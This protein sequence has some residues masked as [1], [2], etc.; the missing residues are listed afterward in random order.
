M[1]RWTRACGA[2]ARRALAIEIRAPASAPVMAMRALERRFATMTTTTTT[3]TTAS[4]ASA[5]AARGRGDATTTTTAAAAAAT[6]ADATTATV[7]GESARM[8]DARSNESDHGKHAMTGMTVG[9][10][11]GRLRALERDA[12]R[13]IGGFFD[14]ASVKRKRK[15]AMN[16]H[17]HRKRRRRDRHQ[18]K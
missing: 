15:K 18:N 11:L 4:A 12:E 6:S 3:T 13:D 5:A 2:L 9:A 8:V 16:K 10:L 14:M 17:K 1:G 7:F